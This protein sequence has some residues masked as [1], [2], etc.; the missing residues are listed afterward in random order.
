MVLSLIRMPL[1]LLRLYTSRCI[2]CYLKL[3]IYRGRGV[4]LLS[5]VQ[6]GIDVDRS[7]MLIAVVHPHAVQQ[8][9]GVG[10]QM[11]IVRAQHALILVLKV[12]LTTCLL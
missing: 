1:I 2:N 11:D 7:I 4:R 5:L 8:G 12:C 10:K 6:T 3:T 9:D